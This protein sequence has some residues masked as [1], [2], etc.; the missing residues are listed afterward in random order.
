[1]GDTA[2]WDALER[3]LE[4]IGEAAKFIPEKLRLAAPAIP[5]EDVVGLRNI[6][7]HAYFGLEQDILWD[8]AE[9]WLPPLKSACERLLGLLPPKG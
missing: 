5:W 7:A 3:N 2:F 6:L 8:I 4:V 9:N 1:M